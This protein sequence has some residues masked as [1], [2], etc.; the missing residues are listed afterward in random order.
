MFSMHDDNAN[1]RLETWL[2]SRCQNRQT[3]EK[4]LNKL[5]LHSIDK[6]FRFYLSRPLKFSRFADKIEAF[7][8]VEL[9]FKFAGGDLK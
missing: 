3:S 9:K 1:A 5:F 4:R 6:H 2:Q 7:E 8:I